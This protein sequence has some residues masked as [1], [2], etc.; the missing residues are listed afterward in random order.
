VVL[1]PLMVAAIR[2]LVQGTPALNG[3][4][5]L[6]ELMVRDV[7]TAHTPLVGSY[8]RFGW[9]QPG[10]LLFYVLTVPYRLAGSEFAG[11]QLGALLLN[12]ASLVGIAIVGLRRGGAVLGLWALLLAGVLAWG[13]GPGP[14][15]DPWEP[16]ALVLPTAFLVLLAYHVA[17]GAAWGLPVVAG[18]ATLLAQSYAAHASVAAALLAWAAVALV[19]GAVRGGEGRRLLAP[20]LTTA[21]VL[22]VLWSPPLLEQ[23]RGDP[24]NLT[25]AWRFL[26][27]PH[28]TLGLAD[29]W[30]AVSLQLGR[31]PPWLGVDVPLVPLTATVDVHAAAVPVALLALGVG[32]G[33]AA[34]RRDRSVLLGVTALV[35][36]GASTFGLSRLVGELFPWIVVPTRAAGFACWLAAGWC[37]YAGLGDRIR[38]RLDRI[39]V[40]GLAAGLVVVSVAG[41]V[42]AATHDED[43]PVRDALVRLGEAGA[44]DLRG[45]DG[46]VLVR[47]EAQDAR[48][49]FGNGIGPELVA[50]VLE[51]DGIDV[52]VDRRLA[53][54]FGDHRAKPRTALADLVL[55]TGRPEGTD[56][57]RRVATADPI[58]RRARERRVRLTSE[59][60]R[61]AARVEGGSGSLADLDEA[62][63][64]DPELRRLVEEVSA[65]PEL[66]EL[67][68]LTRRR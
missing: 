18:V 2:V 1:V 49:V 60:E 52:V 40:P 54:R 46:P 43:D 48:L 63:E 68:V 3:D 19:V 11:L 55:V 50:L 6:I 59:L 44:A 7:G 58:G 41:V 9:N 62:M 61:R 31:R 66:P 16:H 4:D 27:E 56:G 29:A 5:A 15:A 30:S 17:A 42:D 25:E 8:Q 51:R 39:V 36:V 26:R 20:V 34:W 67:S 28:S 64:E 38:V 13:L 22:L 33:V 10:A 32:L 12:A 14:L 21:A 35:V 57:F 47:S 65:I 53:N 45:V 23:V 24:G 37:C